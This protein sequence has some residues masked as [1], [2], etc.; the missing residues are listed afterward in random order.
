[1]SI[2]QKIENIASFLNKYSEFLDYETT[3]KL[4]KVL[5]EL[6]AAKKSGTRI[7][8]FGNHY[9]TC[10]WSDNAT[11]SGPDTCECVSLNF[12][13]RDAEESIENFKKTFD[14]LIARIKNI[15]L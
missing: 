8:K 4:E 7:S 3:I 11:T 14:N 12:K 15:K 5:K 2:D 1:M 13:Y 9:T 10:M 6:K